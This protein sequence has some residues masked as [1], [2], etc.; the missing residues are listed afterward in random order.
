LLII[1]LAISEFLNC[2]EI[3]L[4]VTINEYLEITKSYSTP[5]SSK[6]VNG[7]LDKLRLDLESRGEIQKT[8]RGLK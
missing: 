6:F 5:S 2:P 8:G 4:R 7:I 1:K 3:P